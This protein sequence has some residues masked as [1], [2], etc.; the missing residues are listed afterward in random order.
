MFLFIFFLVNLAFASNQAPSLVV[1]QL[2]QDHPLTTEELSLVF[3]KSEVALFTNTNRWEIPAQRNQEGIFRLGA[4][5][6]GYEPKLERLRD[7]V[8]R[9]QK[10]LKAE[11]LWKRPDWLKRASPSPPP[12]AL[13][14]TIDGE[15]LTKTNPEFEKVMEEVYSLFALPSWK[16]VD[17]LEIPVNDFRKF[18]VKKG[19]LARKLQPGQMEGC[20]LKYLAKQGPCLLSPLGILHP[21][22]KLK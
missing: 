4:F 7:R 6:S 11:P 9:L 18:Q 2:R 15:E 8:L 5:V 16:M 19:K 22:K 14:M 21:M 10:W 13:K 3:R 17:G 20:W 12:H 1:L